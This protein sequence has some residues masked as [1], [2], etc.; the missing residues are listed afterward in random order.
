ME[1]TDFNGF[2][3]DSPSMRKEMKF[4]VVRKG[5]LDI[6]NAYSFMSQTDLDDYLAEPMACDRVEAVFKV[7]DITTGSF[8]TAMRNI[9]NKIDNEEDQEE[10]EYLQSKYDE[11]F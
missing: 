6:N 4:L 10:K 9:R 8:L 1:R 2:M 3:F 7:S 5:D 11:L